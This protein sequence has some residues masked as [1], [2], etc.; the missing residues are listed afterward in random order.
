MKNALF[1]WLSQAER[2]LFA[3]LLSGLSCCSHSYAENSA[4]VEKFLSQGIF[5][6]YVLQGTNRVENAIKRGKKLAE[7]PTAQVLLLLPEGEMARVADLTEFGIIPLLAPVN[8]EKCLIILPLLQANWVK[9]Q[10]IHQ[11]NRAL[12]EKIQGIQFVNRAKFL[13]I[14]HLN[15]SETQAHKY[16]EKEAMNR[17]LSKVQVAKKILKTY[18]NR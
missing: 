12:T 1:I 6:I 4:Q 17:R 7:Q 2:E 15:M 5:D 16:M 18:D 11:E 14:S 10:K 13:L 8:R 3:E 9:L